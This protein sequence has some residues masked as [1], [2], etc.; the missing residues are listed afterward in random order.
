[1]K[2][3]RCSMPALSDAT[4]LATVEQLNVVSERTLLVDLMLELENKVQGRR[5]QNVGFYLRL[6][7]TFAEINGMD[8]TDKLVHVSCKTKGSM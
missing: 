4:S 7:D 1:M 3:V 8:A 2:Q 5:W 6:T